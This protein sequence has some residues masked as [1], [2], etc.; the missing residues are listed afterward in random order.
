MKKRTLLIVYFLTAAN[1]HAET[2]NIPADQPTIQAGIDA[3]TNGDTVLVQ[4][5][6]WVENINFSG[7]NIVLAS[8]FLTTSDTS[9]ISQTAIDGNHT[10]SVITFENGEDS[11]AVLM[12]FTIQNGEAKLGAGILCNNSHPKLDNLIISNNYLL[13]TGEKVA[14][15]IA[16]APVRL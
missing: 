7:K 10:S 5:G 1:F 16:L 12:G 2:I 6:T 15:S 9:Y 11:T 4:P 8:L 13:L 3:A 14:V